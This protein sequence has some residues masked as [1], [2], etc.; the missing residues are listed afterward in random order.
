MI[1]LCTEGPAYL[2]SHLWR[3]QSFPGLPGRK[4][5]DVFHAGARNRARV[6]GQL[7][8]GPAGHRA[9]RKGFESAIYFYGPGSLNCLATRGFPT[10]GNSAFP[11]EHNINDS[12]KTFIKEA[13]TTCAGVDA[14][15]RCGPMVEYE[16]AW[17]AVVRVFGR[18]RV[19][20]YLLVG[21]GEDPDELVAATGPTG[22]AGSSEPV[23]SESSRW[24]SVRWTMTRCPRWWPPRVCSLSRPPRR[25]SGRPRWKRWRPASRWS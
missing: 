14:R 17:D 10:T 8:G 7:R 6:L 13:T 4:R 23:S 11:G 2:A 1:A 9:K 18:N 3:Y 22:P 20:T 12:L 5:R 25:A 24:C 21:L 16:A 15:Q 19:S